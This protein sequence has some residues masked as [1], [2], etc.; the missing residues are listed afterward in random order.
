MKKE[1][2]V[3]DLFHVDIWSCTGTGNPLVEIVI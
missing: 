2:N 3:T 1:N